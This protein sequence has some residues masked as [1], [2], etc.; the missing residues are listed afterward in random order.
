MWIPGHVGIKG[1]EF[2]D[3]AAKAALTLPLHSF[4]FLNKKTISTIA[5]K[6]LT[7]DIRLNWNQYNHHYK[8]FNQNRKKIVLPSNTSV[9]MN[10]IYV[11]L[12][13]GHTVVTHQHLFTKEH[14]PTCQYCNNTQLTVLH[15]LT[16]SSLLQL[17]QSIFNNS[18]PLSCLQNPTGKNTKCTYDFISKLKLSKL[19]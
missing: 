4:L 12:R 13:L 18:P 1:N 19:I 14:P 2:A 5:R 16:C 10:K 9:L 6:K 8:Q 17:H 11:R 3:C 7:A 15:L